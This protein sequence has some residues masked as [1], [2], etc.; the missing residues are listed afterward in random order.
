MRK[1]AMPQQFTNPLSSEIIQKHGIAIRVFGNVS[2]LPPDVQLAASK[3]IYMTRQNTK[4]ILNICIPY[5]SREEMTMAIKDVVVGV[6]RNDLKQS[7]ITEEVLEECLYTGL[8]SGMMT[9]GGG[10]GGDTLEEEDESYEYMGLPALDMLVRTSGEVRLSDFMLWQVCTDLTVFFFLLSQKPKSLND[11]S[12]I[13]GFSELLHPFCRYPLAPIFILGHVTR[14]T[15][16]SSNVLQTSTIS[17]GSLQTAEL[18][19][20]RQRKGSNS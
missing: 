2:L 9:Q 18:H 11:S 16:I 10:G 13:S 14:I 17:S 8:A 6:E 19:P 5:T 3:A 20:S 12:V 1:T 7:D 15:H 4:A